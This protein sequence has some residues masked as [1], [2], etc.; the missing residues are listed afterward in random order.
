MRKKR[1]NSGFTLSEVRYSTNKASSIFWKIVIQ[2]KIK[3]IELLKRPK[4]SQYKLCE[5][6]SSFLCRLKLVKLKL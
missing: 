6:F 2:F 3:Y 5:K 1:N 4:S